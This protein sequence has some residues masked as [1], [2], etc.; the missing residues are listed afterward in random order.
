MNTSPA[1]RKLIESF[2]GL[3]LKA[4]ADQRGIW[5]LGYGHAASVKPADTCTPEQADAWLAGDLATAEGAVSRLV[6]VPLNQN[7]FD[8]L[9]SLCFNIGQ[10]SFHHST[11]LS[12]LN[13][14]AYLGAA[15]Q[16][17]AWKMTNGVPNQGLL[18]RRMQEKALFLCL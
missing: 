3:A 13:Q 2:E 14:K 1:G 4:Y 16:F 9:V 8:A 7:Q 18:N 5:T 17:L 10:G 11:L 12:L 15:N 6:T